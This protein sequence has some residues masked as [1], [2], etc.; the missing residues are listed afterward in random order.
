MY[1]KR[2]DAKQFKESFGAMKEASAASVK[3]F[4]HDDALAVAW[5]QFVMPDG[6]TYDYIHPALEGY[7]GKAYSIDEL[8]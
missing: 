5:I 3:L 4:V 7:D 2:E 1:I 6:R 8:K